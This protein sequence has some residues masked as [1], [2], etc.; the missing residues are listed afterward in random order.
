MPLLVTA[1]LDALFFLLSL[2]DLRS[3]SMAPFETIN[4]RHGPAAP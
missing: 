3:C 2:P 4:E 1:S